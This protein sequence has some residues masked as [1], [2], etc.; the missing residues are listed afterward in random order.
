[1]TNVLL[2]GT[3]GF[4]GKTLLKAFEK[5]NVKTF[6]Y[7]G[8]VTQYQEFVSFLSSVNEVD[9]TFHFAGISSVALCNADPD[10][11][12]KVNNLSVQYCAEAISHKFPDSVFILPSTGQVYKNSEAEK[13]LSEDSEIEPL[14]FYAETKW[15]AE[16]SLQQVSEKTDLKSLVLRLFNHTHKNQ[17]SHF[18]L[19]SLYRQMK[20]NK[21]SIKTGNLDL[22]R[23][24]GA[25]QDLMAAFLRLVSKQPSS[26]FEVYN[27]CSGSGKHLGQIASELAK[28]MSVDIKFEKDVSL[29]RVNEPKSIIGSAE[30]FIKDYDWNPTHA[31]NERALVKSFLADL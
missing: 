26:S 6:V 25:I 19:P 16:Y 20:E 10:K 12:N 29:I 21:K 28:Q 5:Q 7:P 30:K 27:V 1:M 31:L 3:Q 17:N 13:K 23:D 24:L 18:F 11:A 9:Y 2:T 8:D 14:N 4:L 15:K 22:V